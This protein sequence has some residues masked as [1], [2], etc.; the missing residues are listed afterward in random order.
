V[1]GRFARRIDS[2]LSVLDAQRSHIAAQQGLVP[3]RLTKLASRV[4]LYEVLGG[5]AE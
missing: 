5:G 4:R 2:Y 3:L 1:N